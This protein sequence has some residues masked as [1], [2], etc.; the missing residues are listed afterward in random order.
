[1]TSET[2]YLAS[3]ITQMEARMIDPREFGRLEAEVRALQVEVAAL[4]NDMRQLLE[5]AN[6]GKGGFWVGMSI[7]SLM[8]GVVTFVAGKLL[9]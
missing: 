1:M 6:Q 5:L 2:D 8:G 4:R 3:V 7:A 9:R